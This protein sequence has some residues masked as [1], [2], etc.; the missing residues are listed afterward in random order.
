MT[1]DP[2]ILPPTRPEFPLRDAEAILGTR[3]VHAPA[4]LGR[5]G[6]YRDTMG[7]PGVNER[8]IYDDAIILVTPRT[9]ATFNANVDPS[10]HRP[11]IAT[12]ALGVWKYKPGIHNLSKDPVE[13]PRYP[14][15]V[16]AGPVT[17]LR[18]GGQSETGWL[19]INIHRGGDRGT[20]SLG[21][22][23]VHPSQWDEFITLVYNEMAFY[24]LH[25]IAYV[26]TGRPDDVGMA[27]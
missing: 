16:Q 3:G 20:S 19:G 9:Y 5:R 8:G 1:L 10:R 22:Q 7:K 13:H 11:G 23:T 24:Q 6:Y 18:D 14:A 4:L 26:L 12:L 2:M 17:V 25:W 27:A 15:L 21:C